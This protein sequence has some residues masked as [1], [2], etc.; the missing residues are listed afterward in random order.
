MYVAWWMDEPLAK[1]GRPDGGWRSI[2]AALASQA[3]GCISEGK[4]FAIF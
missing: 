4:L 3:N 2:A 1:A